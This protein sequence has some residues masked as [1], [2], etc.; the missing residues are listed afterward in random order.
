MREF[1]VALAGSP[2]VGKSTLFNRMTGGNV[3]VANWAGVTLQ[4]FEGVLNYGGVRLRIVDLPGTYSLSARD[5]GER[6]AR[7][8]IV[9]ERP[10]VLVLIAD[11]TSLEKSLYLVVSA[12]ELY[13]RAVLALNMMDA[14]EKRGIHVNVEGLRGRLGVPVVP[15][16]A[17]KKLGMG[18]LLREII[19]V[20]EGGAGREEPLRVNYDGLERFIARLERR[21]REIGFEGYPLR[22]AAVRLLEGDEVLME[23]LSKENPELA[24]EVSSLREEARIE[25]ATDPESLVISSRYGFIEEVLRENVR[26]VGLSGPS[27]EEALDD[28]LLH[29]IAGPISSVAIILATFFAVFTLNTGFPAN[30]ILRIMGFETLSDLIE[31]YSLTGLLGSLLDSVSSGVGYAL[32][33]L[34]LGDFLVRLLSEG[35]LGSFGTLISFIPLLM[36]TYIVLGALQD[37]GILPRAAASLD[38]LFRRFGLSG[39]A[40][41][42]AALGLGCNVPGVIAT[43]GLEDEEE[44]IVVSLAEPFIPCQARL[45]VLVAIAAAAFRD[46]LLQASLMASVYLLGVL[47]FLLSSKMLRKLLFKA[48]EVPELLME[49]PPYHAPSVSVIWWYTKANTLHFLRKAGMIILTLGV[50][51]WL[52]LNFGPSGSIE[53]ASESFASLAGGLLAPLLSPVGLNDWRFALAL[54]VGFIAKEGLLVIFSSITGIA[55]PVSAIREVGITPLRAASLAL[56]MSFYVP[57]LATLS[58]ILSELKAVKYV[59]IAIAMELAVAFFLS[60]LVYLTGSALG[61]K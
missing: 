60:S 34:G 24:S 43:R 8:F 44:R 10:D 42:P 57:C 7:E 18:N 59:M 3:Q 1:L 45:V 56:L 13:G 53:D 52:A 38:S 6:I 37:S 58:T 31:S 33:S 2:N 41:F 30:L 25:L 39:K 15:I 35:V 32:S 47:T 23:E 54:E 11:A 22:W 5:V 4:K 20:A 29:P 50:L 26:R 21:L 51:S 14:A 16:S 46:P 12:L 40:F 48:R 28:V 17:L 36:I 9:K 19:E 61:F 27:L 49:L 55:D